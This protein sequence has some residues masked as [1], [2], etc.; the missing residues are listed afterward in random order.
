MKFRQNPLVQ[1]KGAIRTEGSLTKVK[2]EQLG[3]ETWQFADRV[4]FVQVIQLKGKARTNVNG[5]IEFQACTDEKCLPNAVI[6]FQIP[7]E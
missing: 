6:N 3:I 7:I 1:L 5:S 2:E 4:S